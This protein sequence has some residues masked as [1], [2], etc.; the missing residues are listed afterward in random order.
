MTLNFTTNVNSAL[1]DGDPQCYKKKSK[2][3]WSKFS[4]VDIN[5]RYVIPLLYDLEKGD[6]DPTDSESAVEKISKLLID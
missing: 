3:F 5:T 2:V 1:Y 4:L 6:I